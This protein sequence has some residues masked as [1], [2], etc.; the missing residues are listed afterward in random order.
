MAGHLDGFTLK[1]LRRLQARAKV[2]AQAIVEHM[3]ERG[4]TPEGEYAREAIETIIAV[5]RSPTHPRDKVTAA[6]MLL[7]W[8][9]GKPAANATVQN[10]EDLLLELAKAAGLADRIPMSERR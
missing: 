2:E 3:S 1:Q 5:L 8:T 10:A 9:R 7:E 6:R 4:V